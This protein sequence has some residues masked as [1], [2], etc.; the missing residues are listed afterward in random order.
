MVQNK[1]MVQN[2]W[3]NKQHNKKARNKGN[4]INGCL[5]Q[6]GRKQGLGQGCETILRN[7]SHIEC[8]G[9]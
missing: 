5:A 7:V 9:R 1:A 3:Q 8:L 2:R 6:N 4:N